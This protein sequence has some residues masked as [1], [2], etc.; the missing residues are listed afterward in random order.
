[1][2]VLVI[3]GTGRCGKFV[4]DELLS[5]GYQV[6]TLARNPDALSDIQAAGLKIIQGTPT[7][8]DDVRVAFKAD[9]PDA[10]IVTLNAPR[11]NDSPFAA[12][13]S[14][15]RLMTDC[16]ANV[17]AAMKEFGVRKTVILQ[18]FGVGD[19]WANMHCLLRLLMAKSNMSYQYDDHND[20]ER[21]VRSS[22]VDYVFVRPSRLVDTGAMPIRVWPEDGKGVPMMAST[23]RISVARWLVDAVESDRWDN[24]APV[25]TN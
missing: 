6:T 12:P 13:I 5:R 24:S 14:P 8:L 3:G 23:S 15:P 10:V 21:E 16:N 7:Q 18:A 25:I 2:R 20:T 9:V 1:M 11:A 19:S 22:G 17:V 4:I